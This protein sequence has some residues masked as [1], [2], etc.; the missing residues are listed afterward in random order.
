MRR[1]QRIPVATTLGEAGDD[2]TRRNLHQY[3]PII[4]FWLLRA[5]I[6]PLPSHGEFRKDLPNEGVR[7]HRAARWWVSMQRPIPKIKR[8]ARIVRQCLTGKPQRKEDARP[9]KP[10]ETCLSLCNGN[11]KVRDHERLPLS[12]CWRSWM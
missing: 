5:N 3:S 4:R 10:P 2:K 7:V 6:P 1:Y 9:E 8:S 11:L 12:V